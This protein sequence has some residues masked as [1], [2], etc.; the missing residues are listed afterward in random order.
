MNGVLVGDYGP[1]P[2]SSAAINAGGNATSPVNSFIVKIILILL[3]SLLVA[4]VL[5]FFR[6]YN[7]VNFDSHSTPKIKCMLTLE[8]QYRKDTE[9]LYHSFMYSL[10]SLLSNISSMLTIESRMFPV[11]GEVSCCIRT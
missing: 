4:N 5:L 3:S 2:A 11:M 10:V 8:S 7:L 9:T 6:L 1:R